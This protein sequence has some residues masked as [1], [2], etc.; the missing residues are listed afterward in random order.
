MIDDDVAGEV[1]LRQHRI[2]DLREEE[3]QLAFARPVGISFL[4]RPY[5]EPTLIRLAYAFEQ[6]TKVRVPPTFLTSTS[7]SAART[8]AAHA[9]KLQVAPDR[10]GHWR[11][12]ALR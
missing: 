4:G 11:M 7:A 3:M 5:S 9:Q 8:P 1:R 2:A 6:A 12:P 10:K